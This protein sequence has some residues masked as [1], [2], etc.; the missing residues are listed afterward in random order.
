MLVGAA[1][2]NMLALTFQL[3]KLFSEGGLSATTLQ[4]LCTA[5]LEDGWGVN[6]PVA[7]KLARL[8][9]D[10]RQASHCLR[11]LMRLL[12]REGLLGSTPEPYLV[13]VPGPKGSQRTVSVNL[14][15]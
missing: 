6:D 8:G 4:I 3:L 1:R 5:A 13:K 2:L 9:N 11:D 10:G 7:Q 14:P 12:T 15:H